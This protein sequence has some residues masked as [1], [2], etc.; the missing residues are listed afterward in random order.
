M[1]IKLTSIIIILCIIYGCA[2]PKVRDFDNCWSRLTKM[3]QNTVTMCIDGRSAIMRI[4]YPN[5]GGRGPLEPTIC[6]QI[7][8]RTA[9]DQDGIFQVRFKRGSCMNGRQLRAVKLVCQESQSSQMICLDQNT[10]EQ[11]NFER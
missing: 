7:G 1:N 9:T 10:Q 4:Y 11:L 6:K 5:K 2:S 8:D 3:T